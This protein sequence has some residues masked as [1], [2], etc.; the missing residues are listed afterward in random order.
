MI[1]VSDFL[2]S[3]LDSLHTAP[4]E[5]VAGITVGVLAVAGFYAYLISLWSNH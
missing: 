1:R 2:V 5:V 4:P 3:A